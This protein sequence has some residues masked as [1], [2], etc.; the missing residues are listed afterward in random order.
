[1]E[2][3]LLVALGTY[4]KL[5]EAGVESTKREEVMVREYVPASVSIEY[6]PFGGVA[7][8]VGTSLPTIEVVPVGSGTITDGSKDPER[9]F[10]P[11]CRLAVF[12]PTIVTVV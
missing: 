2:G 8:V 1:M 11:T 6:I 3:R 5:N 7:K 9:V 12:C 4:R 10:L